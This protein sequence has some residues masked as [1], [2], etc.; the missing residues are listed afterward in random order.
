MINNAIM[1]PNQMHFLKLNLMTFYGLLQNLY[2]P[3]PMRGV[4]WVLLKAKLGMA[5]LLEFEKHPFPHSY[6]PSA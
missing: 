1:N 6:I 3:N 4:G 5:V 2:I